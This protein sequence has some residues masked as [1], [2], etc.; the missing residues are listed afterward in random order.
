MK[1]Y[2]LID[3][4]PPLKKWINTQ[5]E[6]RDK[7]ILGKIIPP[8]RGK[9]RKVI[10]VGSGTGH[11]ALS[12][13]KLGHKV[14]CVDVEDMNLFEETK[15]II[16]DGKTLPFA[17]NSF[18]VALL[19]TVLHHTP[20]P[21]VVIREVSRVAKRIVIMEDTY[22]NLWQKYLTFIMDSIGNMQFKNHPHSNKTDKEWRKLFK[23][24]RLKVLSVK[25]RNF[26]TYLK[27]QL[28]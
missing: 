18:E 23:K 8:L 15:P 1:L 19:V 10:D 12:L 16:Y 4:F 6:N 11:T 3:S 13:I 20:N 7:T 25:N 28:I 17:D 14:T 5:I 26:S 9:E 21:E 24:L 22:N 27:A 2:H